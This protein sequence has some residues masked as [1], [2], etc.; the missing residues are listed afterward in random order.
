[1]QNFME[2]NKREPNDS[3]I[4]AIRN[5]AIELTVESIGA[6]QAEEDDEDEDDED[7]EEGDSGDNEGQ[8]D[9]DEPEEAAEEA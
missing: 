6:G 7:N 3:E 4:E 2:E 9:D 5:Q 8:E 1:M